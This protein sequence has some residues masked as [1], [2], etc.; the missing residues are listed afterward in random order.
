MSSVILSEGPRSKR[1]LAPELNLQAI[2]TE[3]ANGGFEELFDIEFREPD[4]S[5]FLPPAGA[6]I[7]FDPTPGGIVRGAGQAPQPDRE[8]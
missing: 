6:S 4:S 7:R 8:H 3:F 1:Y 5:E 2:R